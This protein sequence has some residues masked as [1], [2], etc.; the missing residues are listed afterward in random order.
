MP[1][2]DASVVL[3]QLSGVKLPPAT[4]A[5][6]SNARAGVPNACAPNWTHKPPPIPVNWN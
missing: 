4:L 1:I 3:E 2:A 6:K 5:G